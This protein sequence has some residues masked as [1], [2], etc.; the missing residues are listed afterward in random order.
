MVL[1]LTLQYRHLII[2]KSDYPTLDSGFNS[3]DLNFGMFDRANLRYTRYR[4]A[5]DDFMSRDKIKLREEWF[6]DPQNIGLSIEE[7]GKYDYVYADESVAGLIL[8]VLNILNKEFQSG[9][10]DWRKYQFWMCGPSS[11]SDWLYTKEATLCHHKEIREVLKTY[12]D[13]NRFNYRPIFYFI[14][15]VIRYETTNFSHLYS[16]LCDLM[17]ETHELKESCESMLKNAIEHVQAQIMFENL[18]RKGMNQVAAW[19]FDSLPLDKM[20]IWCLKTAREAIEATEGGIEWVKKDGSVFSKDPV[21]QDGIRN[22][23]KIDEPGHS[24]ASISWTIR[25][26]QHIYNVGWEEYVKEF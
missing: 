14:N 22:H 24:G 18:K 26:L 15:K 25:T 9:S 2:K 6:F 3:L 4:R 5:V 12:E 17:K 20:S 16:I 10:L 1:D 8:D 13:A 21:W 7:L 19:D 11:F 23:P